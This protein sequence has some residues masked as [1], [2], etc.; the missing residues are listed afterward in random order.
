MKRKE[1]YAIAEQFAAYD[2]RF[3]DEK[4]SFEILNPHGKDAV[5]VESEGGLQSEPYIVCYSFFHIHLERAEE[6]I[7]YVRD[8]LE[9]R[10]LVIG[11]FKDGRW[12]MSADL[13]EQAQ[14]DLSYTGLSKRMNMGKYGSDR[15]YGDH[16]ELI[17]AADSFCVRG[18]A[19]DVD[20]DAVFVRDEQGNV[21]IQTC[22]A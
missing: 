21:T 12:S 20:F 5:L 16:R 15:P 8:I 4:E 18:W 7:A 19:Q 2:V 1:L 10:R 9:G 22:D 11:F 13:D 14:P 6:V 3:S 17:E